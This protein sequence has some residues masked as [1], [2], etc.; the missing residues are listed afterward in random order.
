M[1]T[2][3]PQVDQQA[4]AAAAAKAAEAQA[5]AEAKAAEKAAKEEA[6]KAEIEA[7][8]AAKEAEAAAKKA[9][10]EAERK[11]KEEAKKAEAEAK[12]K[13]KVQM[14]EQNGIRRPKPETICGR[15]WA[16]L[17]QLSAAKGAPL[18]IGELMDAT[19]PQSIDQTTV[20]CQYAAWRKFYGISG[21]IENPKAVAQ[22]EAKAAEKAA[23]KQAQK[24]EAEAKKAAEKAN[25]EAAKA[26]EK[27]AKEAAKNAA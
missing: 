5:K 27:A 7:K 4:E 24:A 22:K 25:R 9:A 2:T 13:T 10:K 17:D 15:I 1:A 8:K 26:A 3:K 20:R 6:K 14:P 12:A 21:R 18:S 16:T 23:A 11:A 19:N